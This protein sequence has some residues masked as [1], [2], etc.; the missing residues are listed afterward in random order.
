MAGLAP[1]K[2]QSPFA[3]IEPKYRATQES[4]TIPDN[5]IGPS[6]NGFPIYRPQLLEYVL[7]SIACL[8]TSSDILDLTTSGF[9]R[10]GSFSFALPKHQMRT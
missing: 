5:A 10:F 8:V 6:S 1:K 7:C 4:K 9:Y 2:N 3:C